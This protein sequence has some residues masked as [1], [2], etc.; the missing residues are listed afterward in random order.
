L[1]KKTGQVKWTYNVRNDGDQNNFHG[2]PLI[3]DDLVITSTD[4]GSRPTGIGG[5]YAFEKLTG[6][7]RWRFDGGRGVPTGILRLGKRI[8]FVTLN[9]E[10]LS[11]DLETGRRIWSFGGRIINDQSFINITPVGRPKVVFFGALNGKVYALD[12]ETG[13]AVW[14]RD[15]GSRISSLVLSTNSLY[16]G[17]ASKRIY[18]LK[19][20]T[21]EVMREFVAS[22]E[23]YWQFVLSRDSLIAHLGEKTLACLPK[24]LDKPQWTQDSTTPWSSSRPYVWKELTIVGTEDGRVDA[25]QLA[26][27]KLKWTYKFTGPIGGIGGDQDVLYIGTRRG[28]LYA[29]KPQ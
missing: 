23:L 12:S 26:D 9:D 4:G 28:R 22:A 25:L 24:S 27:G 11:I 20:K 15:L 14:E 8:Y 19:G 10:L 3:T 29:F 21:G 18:H 13:K 5:V 1:D 7:V 16:A 2:D 17:T 6:K